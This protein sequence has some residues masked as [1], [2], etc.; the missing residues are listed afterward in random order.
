LDSSIQTGEA[1]LA[2]SSRLP[3]PHT[4]A[5]VLRVLAALAQTPGDQATA[6]ALAYAGRTIAERHEFPYW[7]AWADI[8]L[9]WSQRQAGDLGYEEAI[10]QI[11]NA[12]RAYR[13]TGAAQALPYAL[14]LLA[15]VALAYDRPHRAL[16]AVTEGWQ[17][18]ERYGL[19]LYAS[20]LLRIRAVAELRSGSDL[21]DVSKT[22][23]QAEQ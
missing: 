16:S 21:S 15:D 17:L 7:V 8:I 13:R 9:G 12:I 1:A 3:H 20:E 23:E 11:E 22:L 10:Q 14:L 18:A 2:P 19:M 6:S 4:S 5:H